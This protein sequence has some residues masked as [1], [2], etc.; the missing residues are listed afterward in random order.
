MAT[1]LHIRLSDEIATAVNAC[2]TAERRK[3]SQ[4]AHCLIAEALERRASRVTPVPATASA[5]PEWQPTPATADSSNG[6]EPKKEG[7]AFAG[8]SNARTIIDARGASVASGG[9]PTSRTHDA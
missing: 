1:I 6:N 5:G 9:A 7:E 4:M 3:V 8:Q 2:A